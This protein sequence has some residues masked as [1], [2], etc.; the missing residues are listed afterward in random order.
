MSAHQMACVRCGELG[1]LGQRIQTRT[2]LCVTCGDHRCL[3]GE[4]TQDWRSTMCLNCR[5][6]RNNEKKATPADVLLGELRAYFDRHGVAPA[7]NG[8]PRKSAI[9][10]RFG[11]W[12]AGVRAA[13]LP[14]RP[15]AYGRSSTPGRKEDERTRRTRQMVTGKGFDDRLDGTVKHLP[16]ARP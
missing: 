1:W 11:S 13:G 14:E 16:W 12:S 4:T 5:C 9:Q 10:Q 7:C 8:W 2:H 15:I 3:C 6:R